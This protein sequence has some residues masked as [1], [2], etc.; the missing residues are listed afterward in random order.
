M[1]KILLVEDDL[2]IC[3]IIR[4][5]FGNKGTGVEVVNSGRRASDIIDRGL[6]GYDLVLLDIMLPETD[7]FELCRRIRSENDIPVIFITAR[8]RE[9]DILSGYDLGCDDYIVKPFL[10][11][12]L[13]SK[14][15]ALVRR[16]GNRSDNNQLTCGTIS[17]DTVT[18][19]C[20]ANGEEV[21]L[22]PKEFAILRYLL[23]HE[24]WTV[25]RDTLLDRVWGYDYF[26]SDRVVDNHIKKLR[27]A[28]GSAGTQIKTLVGRGY[29][30]TKE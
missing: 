18:L 14:C 29:K 11:S 4:E 27:K 28:L 7:G 1:K 24:N 30:L 6:E 8:G 15:E 21:E 9:E 26:G 25:T 23:E 2:D 12:V 3:E 5:Y 22:P 17:L 10:L 16:A 19:R 13:Y 20:F